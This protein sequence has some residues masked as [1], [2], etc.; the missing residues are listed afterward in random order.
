MLL[1]LAVLVGCAER[2]VPIALPPA[3]TQPEP[4]FRLDTPDDMLLYGDFFAVCVQQ[5][6]N[7]L[8]YDCTVRLAEAQG[9][10][11]T[12]GRADGTGK[13]RTL[14]ADGPAREHRF[15]LALMSPLTTYAFE[16]TADDPALE[17]IEGTFETDPLPPEVLVLP[18]RDGTSTASLLA[19]VSPCGLGGYVL[20]MDPNR[21]E[22][23]WY[24]RVAASMFGFVDAVTFTEQGTLL[25]VVDEGL[26]ETTQQGEHVLSLLPGLQLTRRLHH[27]VFRRGERTW[28]L[29]QETLT[30]GAASY[31]ADGFVV[32]E[33][34]QEVAEWHLADHFA[35]PPTTLELPVDW[36]H[37][38]GIW[39]DED[40]LALISLRNLDTVLQVVADPDA[41]DFGEVRW[42]LAGPDGPLGSDFDLSSVVGDPPDFQHQH[43]AYFSGD[44]RITLFDNRA[45]VRETSRVL[46]IALDEDAGTAVIDRV[47]PLSVHCDFSGGALRTAAGNPLATCA[48][49]QQLYE[50][51]AASAQTRYTAELVCPDG[52]G[53]YIPRFVPVTW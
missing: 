25:A 51:D 16:V 14:R 21:G 41:P 40:G 32:I 7:V 6:G 33:G 15:T 47:Y 35:L 2:P 13:Q 18:Q 27:D 52:G 19:F 49:L 9:V 26:T 50:F 8:R 17:P 5:V 37:A 45:D 10:T 43:N 48:P 23:V 24:D 44:G 1:S 53:R 34:G 22:I 20:V 46:E 38:N 3:A 29:F 30:Q 39:V 12:W 11:L 4:R 31:Y 28:S 36:S 42:R